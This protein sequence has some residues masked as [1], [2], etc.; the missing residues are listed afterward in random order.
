M[1]KSKRMEPVLRIAES[2]EDKA[3]QEFAESQ[4]LL[5][6]HERQL[7]Q[8]QGYRRE[9]QMRLDSQAAAGITASRLIETHRFLAQLDKAI[10]QQQMMVEQ[11]T[12]V[13]SQKR[14]RWLAARQKSQTFVKAKERF[15]TL[16][17]Q[18]DDKREQKVSD[19]LAQRRR[20]QDD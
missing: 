16:E 5:G 7:A 1:R 4:R 18:H 19:E 2:R 11:A 14:Q 6:E 17:R 10:T 8:L 12:R 3:A 13:C 20:T 9:Y 15:E